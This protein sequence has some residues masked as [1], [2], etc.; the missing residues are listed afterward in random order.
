M[1]VNSEPDLNSLVCAVDLH[2]CLKTVK[3]PK[4][5]PLLYGVTRS[6]LMKNATWQQSVGTTIT[7]YSLSLS[8]VEFLKLISAWKSQLL[9]EVVSKRIY[10]TWHL[11]TTNYLA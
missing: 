3:T 6:F 5:A 1:S 9:P 8:T 11:P 2:H 10:S 4:L 7:F